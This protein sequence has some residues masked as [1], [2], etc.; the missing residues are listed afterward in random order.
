M[1]ILGALDDPVRTDR[2]H[3]WH[4]HDGNGTFGGSLCAPVVMIIAALWLWTGFTMLS[5]F[6]ATLMYLSKQFP[7]A[8][9]GSGHT[10]GEAFARLFAGVLAPFLMV[11]HPGSPAILFGTMLV[12]VVARAFAPLLFGKETVG[13]IRSSLPRP[14]P[15]SPEERLMPG[16]CATLRASGCSR[17]GQVTLA[18]PQCNGRDAPTAPPCGRGRADSGFDP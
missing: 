7:T 4:R 9:R 14:C 16:S 12:A 18:G 8:L 13:Q 3:S 5:S 10:F 11:R 1:E 2:V 15:N 17:F 6:S